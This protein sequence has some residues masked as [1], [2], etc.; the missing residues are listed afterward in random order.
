M[1][2]CPI[3][4]NNNISLKVGVVT[5]KQGTKKIAL[6]DVSYWYCSNCRQKFYD[7]ASSKAI[8]VKL[9]NKLRRKA[10]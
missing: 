1:K 2:T 8:D 6:E 5:F 3:C 4:E 7:A 10:A 9:R